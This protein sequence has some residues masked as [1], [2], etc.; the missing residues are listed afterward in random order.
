M[1]GL[2]VRCRLF[3][4]V[5]Y[6]RVLVYKLMGTFLEVSSDPNTTGFSRIRLCRSAQPRSRPATHTPGCGHVRVPVTEV[7]QRIPSNASRLFVATFTREDLRTTV[8]N[9]LSVFYQRRR[10]SA[11]EAIEQ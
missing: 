7:G 10:V 3:S 4:M 6:K 5:A 1:A 11:Q 8:Y 2:S 9:V